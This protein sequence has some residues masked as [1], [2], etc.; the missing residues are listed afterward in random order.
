MTDEGN[1]KMSSFS[2]FSGKSVLEHGSYE[3]RVAKAIPSAGMLQEELEV[4]LNENP[5][6]NFVF[7]SYQATRL[8]ESLPPSDSAEL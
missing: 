1:N 5:N 3:I 7:R 4:F 8:S 2:H 6:S